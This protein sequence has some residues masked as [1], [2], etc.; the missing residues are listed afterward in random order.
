LDDSEDYGPFHK[1]VVLITSLN[2]IYQLSG[3]IDPETQS[4]SVFDRLFAR[5]EDIQRNFGFSTGSN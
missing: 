3:P 5:F 1:Y 2:S 4:G